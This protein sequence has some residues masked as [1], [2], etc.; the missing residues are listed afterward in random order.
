MAP[1]FKSGHFQTVD[2]SPPEQVII[3]D[4]IYGTHTVTEPVLVELLRS[5]AVARLAGV[6]QHGISGLLRFTPRVTRMEHSVGAFLLVRMVGGAVDEQVA[7][8]LHDVSHTAMSHVVDFALSAP[9]EDSYHEVH[10]MRYVKTTHIPDILARHGFADL[11]PLDEVLYPLVEQDAPHLCAD[12][13]DYGL[14]D[15]VGFGHMSLEDAKGVLKSLKAFPSPSDPRRILVLQDSQL[16]LTLSRAYM[17][18][19]R[20]VWGNT[21]HG[22]IYIRT[23]NLMKTLIR[24]GT[25]R[26]EE[27]WSLSDDDFWARMRQSADADGQKAMDRLESEGLPDEKGLPLPR[28]AKVRTI[29][30]DIVSSVAEQPQPLSVI[31]PEYDVEKQEYIKMRRALYA[32]T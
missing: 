26:E 32:P 14:R 29:D 20:D 3:E 18:C 5:P 1:P 11:R 9:G 28:G 6:H 17:A 8:L 10:K 16:A 24:N 27:L 13:L 21:A 30:P 4:Q 15:A 31:L 22:D 2:L 7:G 25:V 23:A 19:D 12:R